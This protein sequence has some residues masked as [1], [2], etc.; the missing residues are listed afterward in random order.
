MAHILVVDD[1]PHIRFLFRKVLESVGHSVFEAVNGQEALGILATHPSPFDLIVL[2]V[3][4]PH[5]D[6]F[7]LLPILRRQ[8]VSAHIPVIIATA[9]GDKIPQ[10]LEH[11]IN[12]HLTKPFTRQ[13]LIN[14]VNDALVVRS[15]RSQS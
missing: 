7:A 15:A 6:G 13:K 8:P 4:M 12:G 2:D 1:E 5:M 11:E 10:P 9:H 3:R 14:I